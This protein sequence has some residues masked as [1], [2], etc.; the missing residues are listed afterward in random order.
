MLAA[1]RIKEILL[2]SFAALWILFFLSPFTLYSRTSR[3]PLTPA[4][5][6]LMIALGL[7]LVVTLWYA[8]PSS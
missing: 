3:T 6:A 7:A 5:R 8:L 4:E 1:I 2:F